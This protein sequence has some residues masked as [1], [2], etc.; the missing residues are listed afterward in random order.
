MLNLPNVR[1]YIVIKDIKEL[2]E[3]KKVDIC[4]FIIL[5][6]GNVI[7][8]WRITPRGWEKERYVLYGSALEKDLE[9]TGLK[10][11]Q[12]FYYYAGENEIEKMKHIFNPIERWESYEQLH[13]A[14]Y[15]FAEQKLY[16]PIFQFDANSSFTYG[17]MQL[18]QGFETLKDYMGNLYEKKRLATCKSER[19]KYKNLQNYLVGY[20]ARIKDFVKV[21]SEIIKESNFNIEYKIAEI[22]NKGGEVYIS[23]TDSIIT[24]EK[25]AEI[26]EKYMG[27]K[28]G[29]FKLERT[30]DK[31]FYKSSN[32]YQI[33][34]NKVYSG[35]GYFAKKHTDFFKEETGVQV[36]NFIKQKDFI[37]ETSDSQYSK[38]CRVE[39]GSIK[40]DVYNKIGEKINTF[41]YYAE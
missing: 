30:C 14:N 8:I 7:T 22:V 24:D 34:D 39:L 11:Y 1:N 36:G 17:A 38:L 6:E 10:A 29:Q 9:T 19:S 4:N 3:A 32:A 25:G 5:E 35:L 23:N 16:K 40:V 13:Y 41:T 28:V 21:R 2:Q 12:S 37:L 27:D 15:E 18:P 33:G 20:F 31:L 26:M